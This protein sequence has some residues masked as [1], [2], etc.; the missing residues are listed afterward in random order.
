M[1]PGRPTGTSH[2]RLCAASRVE[3]SLLSGFSGEDGEPV[4]AGEDPEEHGEE[5]SNLVDSRP[6]V[7]IREPVLLDLS[8]ELV[9][10]R[11]FD[12]YTYTGVTLSSFPS[13]YTHFRCS[14][15]K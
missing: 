2:V 6:A 4:R 12:S 14:Y 7:V 1:S 13:I 11:L 8:R 5:G 3:T 15:H 10:A 9:D